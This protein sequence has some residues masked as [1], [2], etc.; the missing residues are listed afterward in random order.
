MSISPQHQGIERFCFLLAEWSVT[1]AK[2]IVEGRAPHARLNAIRAANQWLDEDGPIRWSEPDEQGWRTQLSYDGAI[3]IDRDHALSD[4]IDITIPIIMI[5]L[6][7]G[8]MVIDGWH[9]IFRA[10]HEGVEYLA[11]HI[12]T[13]EEE[14]DCRL[15]GPDGAVARSSSRKRPA[16]TQER[17]TAQAARL[18]EDWRY[19]PLNRLEQLI[20]TSIRVNA[21]G[22]RQIIAA[23]AA[24][25]QNRGVDTGFA[26]GARYDLEHFGGIVEKISE[27]SV[28]E[29]IINSL[30][31]EV[32]RN[33]PRAP[34]DDY[35]HDAAAIFAA[36]QPMLAT[37]VDDR[38]KQIARCQAQDTILSVTDAL[39]PSPGTS[40]VVFT[41]AHYDEQLHI[42]QRV[43]TAVSTADVKLFCRD[44]AN[45]MFTAFE[46]YSGQVH[47]DYT[48]ARIFSL[49]RET[50][51]RQPHVL[52]ID[53]GQ[54]EV[55]G[56]DKI[57][58][59]RT[60]NSVTFQMPE[61]D[62]RRLAMTVMD[63]IR[64]W[65]TL[66]WRKMQ[67]ACEVSVDDELE[68]RL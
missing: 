59:V 68:V 18:R 3:G 20:A 6:A 30:K 8:V 13:E 54:G 1:R 33:N 26:P 22:H 67:D 36:P 61:W 25:E 23:I 21:A 4:A 55:Y 52:R 15:V 62:A 12:L 53:N 10:R 28:D 43:T 56:A 9:R 5:R 19:Q 45:G 14:L 37:V 31:G 41:L 27:E 46:D 42:T 16:R 60:T 65:E 35:G 58:M 51:Y 34:F 39:D 40:R 63:Y 7:G 66:N 48:E 11:A 50:K 44:M 24:A 47:D 32:T 49:K 29:L 57:K 2:E 64:D 17:T 38:I